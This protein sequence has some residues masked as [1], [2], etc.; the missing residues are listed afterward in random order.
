MSGIRLFIQR[1]ENGPLEQVE[2]LPTWL[3]LRVERYRELVSKGLNHDQIKWLVE[4]GE[5]L[6]KD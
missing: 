1:E 5:A 6:T 4:Y 3:L 2:S